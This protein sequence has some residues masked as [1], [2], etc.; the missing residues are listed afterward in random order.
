M[1]N[2][3]TYLL[4]T[5]HFHCKVNVEFEML[6][7][8]ECNNFF[9][10]WGTYFKERIIVEGVVKAKDGRYTHHF[11]LLEICAVSGALFHCC[12]SNCHSLW[13]RPCQSD[14]Y[15][16]QESLCIQRG[17]CNSTIQFLGIYCSHDLWS[18]QAI[19]NGSYSSSSWLFLLR[20]KV[21]TIKFVLW[22]SVRIPLRCSIMSDSTK[23]WNVF[24]EYCML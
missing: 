9:T 10:K 2:P 15:A 21:V 12:G 1:H 19:C 7:P 18:D 4:F 6:Y 23:F 3:K 16:L 13:T 11:C 22:M 24:R 20:L 8:D 17:V 14:E 5:I